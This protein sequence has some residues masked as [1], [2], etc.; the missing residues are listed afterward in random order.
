M[1]IQIIKKNE[2]FENGRRELDYER[3]VELERE[4][5]NVENWAEKNR[6]DHI[7]R[8]KNIKDFEAEEFKP[9][10]TDSGKVYQR[11]PTRPKGT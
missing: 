7:E 9:I 1:G 6:R 8:Q 11:T 3:R 4:R 2:T 10:P 5:E